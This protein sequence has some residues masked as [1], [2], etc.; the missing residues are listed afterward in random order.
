VRGAALEDNGKGC[1]D[2]V[3]TYWGAG[4]PM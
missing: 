4:K 3:R 2:E 1:R